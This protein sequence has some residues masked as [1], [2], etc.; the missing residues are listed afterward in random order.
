MMQIILKKIPFWV[1]FL[2]LSCVIYDL[3]FNQTEE[4]AF[5]LRV[6]YGVNFALAILGLAIL[7]LP[8]ETR[9]PFK[10]WVFD[11]IYLFFVIFGLR[12]AFGFQIPFFQHPNT[13]TYLTAIFVFVREFSALKINFSRQVLNPA[14]LF[15]ASF[16]LIIVAGMLML[17]LPNATYTGIQPIDALFTST[18]AVCVTG[19]AVVDTGT[20]FTTFGQIVIICLIQIGGIGIMTFTSY[21]SYFFRGGASYEN[22]LMLREMTNSEKIAE[23]FGTLKKIILLTLII[24]II[25]AAFIYSSLDSKMF[26]NF[27]DRAYFSGFHAVSA[28]C[29]A[30]FSTLSYGFYDISFRFNYLIQL[31]VAF[32]IIMGGIGFP[33]LFNFLSYFNH[34]IIN[35]VKSLGKHSFYVYKPWI[36]NINTRIVV[37]TTGVLLLF[38]TGMYYWLEYYNTLS[39]HTGFGKVV[40]AFFNSVTSRTAGFNNVDM[41]AL[42]VP[43]SLILIFLMW[44]GASPGGTGGGVKTSTLAVA[45]LN[46]FSLARGKDRVEVYK[47]EISN[48]TLKRASATIA[49]SLVVIGIAVFFITFLEPGKNILDISFECFSAYTTTGLSLGITSGL[50]SGSKAILIGCMFIG[51][52]SMLS[53]MIA[54]FRQVKNLKYRYPSEEIS[55]N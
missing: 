29:N 26:P 35:T 51:R 45:T 52:V 7:Y 4:I 23:V 6:I 37:V 42:L 8:K 9:P 14:Q 33:I 55:I 41:T 46:F 40:V 27:L 2:A 12:L 32:L 39:E 44:V 13:W 1:S 38:G 49:L 47:R 11:G 10:A 17:M 34:L 28:F 31:Y 3:G 43:T 24:E 30:G 50:T 53:L 25:G 18:S 54:F 22:Q 15:V 48:G 5:I 16:A 36:I 20:Y 19:L 21:F